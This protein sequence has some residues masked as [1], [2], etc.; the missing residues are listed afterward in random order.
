MRS[1]AG[2]AARTLVRGLRLVFAVTAVA[3]IASIPMGADVAAGFSYVNF[4]SYFTIQSNV[5]AVGVLLAGAV[6]DPTSDRWQLVRGAVTTYLVIT[7]VVYAVLL[8]DIDV[9]L[10]D[11]WSNSILH[12]VIP[13]VLVLDWLLVPPRR[14]IGLV[15]APTWLV[16]PLVYASYSLIRGAWIGWYP[17][18]FLDPWDKGYPRLMLDLVVLGA[19]MAVLAFG[20]AAIGDLSGRLRRRDTDDVRDVRPLGP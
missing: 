13:L 10:D 4:F 11:R 12:Q 3:A 7:A 1:R 2:T 6:W 5:L 17:Y 20:V 14:P 19:V 9:M 15:R 8:S 16:Y 18:P